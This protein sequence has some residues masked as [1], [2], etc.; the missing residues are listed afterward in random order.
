MSEVSVS[1]QVIPVR[2]QC[3]E[4]GE[5]VTAVRAGR[6][7]SARCPK[8]LEREIKAGMQQR[9][10]APEGQDPVQLLAKFEA[11]GVPQRYL[12]ADISKIGPD[13]AEKL[14]AWARGATSAPWNF[15]MLG[16][17]GTGKTYAVCALVRWM[18]EQGQDVRYTSQA[19]ILRQIRA[20]WA[21]NAAVSEDEVW[22]G[23]RAPRIL[24]IDDVGAARVN[25][26]DV[27]RISELIDMRYND[28][29]PVLLVSN[30]DRDGLRKELGDRAYDRIREGAMTLK[31]A[32]STR[33]GAT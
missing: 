30:L 25:E 20:T 27:L 4:H 24:V 7:G 22:R 19:E 26:N 16:N 9:A 14:Q 28:C 15:V 5:Q 3:A 33:R 31:F 17:I 23:L 8:C 2:T 6:E 1:M 12:G 13:N 18:I 32:G 10:A 29:K 11:R 21:H